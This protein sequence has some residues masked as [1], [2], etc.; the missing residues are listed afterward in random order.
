MTKS[1]MMMIQI[2]DESVDEKATLNY[3]DRKGLL[4][5]DNGSQTLLRIT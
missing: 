4:L 2:C 3:Y 1:M 5:S